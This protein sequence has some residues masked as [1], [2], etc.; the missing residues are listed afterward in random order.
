MANITR[1]DANDLIRGTNNDDI[2]NAGGGNDNIS[3]RDGNDIINAGDGDDFIQPQQGFDTV[4]AGRGND[5]IQFI[6]NDIL[7][8]VDPE[9][10][11]GR[12]EIDTFKENGTS[13]RF[14]LRQRTGSSETFVLG[15]GATAFYV[16]EGNNDFARIENF[17]PE[18]DRIRLHGL[19]EQYQIRRL[20][21]VGFSGAGLFFEDDLIA[22]LK[23]I[24]S[25]DLSLDSDTFTFLENDSSNEIPDIGDEPDNGNNDGIIQELENNNTFQNAQNFGAIDQTPITVVGNL[26]S[27][28]RI[29]PD[30][31]RADIFKVEITEPS[32]FNV[33]L[34]SNDERAASVSLSR[35]FNNDGRS[36]FDDRIRP[37]ASSGP[38]Q[39]SY[40]RLE[41]GTYFIAVGAKSGSVIDYELEFNAPPIETARLNLNLN[42]LTPLDLDRNDP[43]PIRFEAEIGD[44]V[45]EQRFEETFER[46]TLTADVNVNQREIPIKVRAFRL[47]ADGSETQFDIGLG[48]ERGDLQF[49]ATYDTL[50]RKLFQVGEFRSVNEGQTLRQI[51]RRDGADGRFALNV[52]FDTFSEG[53]RVPAL[54]NIQSATTGTQQADTLT[55]GLGNDVL[56]GGLGDDLLTGG[57]GDDIYR[58]ND[59]SDIFAI[60]PGEGRDT[61]RD[62]EDGIDFMGLSNGLLFEDL[63]SVQRGTRTILSLADEQ[64]AVVRGVSARQLTREDF[65][66]LGSTAFQ[67]TMIPVPLSVVDVE[68]P[69]I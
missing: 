32:Q 55:G 43:N 66:T 47:N 7:I 4:I 57:E 29:R 10:G 28:F 1:G 68:Q 62:F 21:G 13:V 48:Q 31:D 19:A 2:I 17:N 52:T 65:V 38:D 46:T 42:A 30:E 14:G 49:D 5:T 9:N 35:D 44:Q 69:V 12:G 40:D 50:T 16:G 63:D 58:G 26:K 33:Q 51:A 22:G 56:M 54:P 36:N 18:L 61:I 11:V 6:G 23:D 60:A 37:S 34:T 64:L 20:R 24:R 27:E 8:G 45:F 41:P 53:Q 67:G 15:N 3:A 59:G 25:N 39:H